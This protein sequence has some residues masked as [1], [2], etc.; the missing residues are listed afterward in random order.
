MSRGLAW[1]ACLL[2]VL[3]PALAP[4]ATRAWLDRDRIES[5]DTVRLTVETDAA[6]AP[7]YAPL[8]ADFD[9]S[10]QSSR[11]DV[12]LSGRGLRRRSTY[13]VTLRPKRDGLLRIPPLR[14]GAASTAALALRVTPSTAP[15]A[16]GAG[17]DVFI[18]SAA[19]DQDPYVQQS[20][21]WVVRL[22]YA[23]PLVSGRLDQDAPEGASLGQVG[24]S[25]YTRSIGGRTYQV[26]ERRYLL[27]PERSG[28]LKMPPARF[29]GQAVGNVFDRLFGDGRVALRARAAP[30]VLKVRP[31][32]A[33]APQP[34]L[35]L[36]GLAMRYTALPQGMRA[37]ASGS[38]AVELVA[39]GA[40]AAQVPAIVFPDTPGA[41]VFAD[42]AQVDETLVDGRPRTTVTRRFSIVPE[43][44]GELRLPGP[45]IDWWDVDAARA[46]STRLPPLELQVEAGVPAPPA[47][48]APADG[49]PG[50]PAPRRAVHATAGWIA[51][52][53]IA[54]LL[55]IAFGLQR[56]ARARDNGPPPA[57]EPAAPSLARLLQLGDLA[58]IEAAL[59]AAAPAGVDDLDALAGAL[60]DPAQR[61]AVLALRQARWA[62]GDP[63]RARSLLRAAFAHGP[64]WNA[65]AGTRAGSLLPPLYPRD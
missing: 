21:G 42:P 13:S 26:V 12:D 29:E 27:I 2:L 59:R 50:I 40:S 47:T 16:S 22:Y 30:R 46:R 37:G 7:D 48:A 63:G 38:V 10:A 20:V 1:L 57:D 8:L 51:L 61:E 3:V 25:Q 41:Q 11:V 6:A 52:A 18:E 64:S 55:L 65:P 44:A 5:G 53:T 49:P 32:P 58:D 39:D 35:P 23:A 31:I 17:R 45:R 19:D 60:A 56:R 36:H 9:L 24:E 34:W 4:A 62:D 15:R 33:D 43:R 28:E 54:A 14:V